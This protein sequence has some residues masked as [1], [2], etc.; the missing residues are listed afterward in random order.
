MTTECHWMMKLLQLNRNIQLRNLT[1]IAGHLTHDLKVQLA[2]SNILFHLDF[3]NA[4]YGALSEKNLQK[5][6]KIQNAA[7][8]FIFNLYG[9]KR[10][11]HITPYL[12]KLHFLPVHLRI[13]YKVALLVFKCLNNQAPKYLSDLLKLRP[14]NSHYLR[15]HND[16]FLL[17][18][19]PPHNL[20]NTSAAFSYNGPKVWNSLPYALRCL[21]NISEF[22]KKLKTHYFTLF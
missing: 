19:P 4:T 3:C 20:K 12:K 6:Q 21:N 17:D 8:R 15:I 11:G 9:K 18:I 16:F 22:K 10:H 2:H 13:K 14:I 5:L 7:V 1:R